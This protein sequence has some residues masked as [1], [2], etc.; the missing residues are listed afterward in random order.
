MPAE[1]TSTLPA[2]E[3]PK[4]HCAS[5]RR[6]IEDGREAGGDGDIPQQITTGSETHIEGT[7]VSRHG[8]ATFVRRCKIYRHSVEGGKEHAVTNAQQAAGQQQPQRGQPD[9]RQ[10]CG[11]VE[12]QHG[13]RHAQPA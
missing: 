9:E 7:V 12:Q 3:Q 5:C 4:S 2:D 13:A 11:N 10:G 1:D 8:L 6:N